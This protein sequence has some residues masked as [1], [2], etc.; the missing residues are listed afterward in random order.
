MFLS[1]RIQNKG[2]EKIA[3]RER[4]MKTFKNILRV[5]VIIVDVLL[6]PAAILCRWLSEQMLE[7][8]SSCLLLQ[9]NGK[10]LSCGGTHFVRDLLS[11]RIFDAFLDNHFFFYVTL[12]LFVTLI[13]ANLYLLFN[14]KFSLKV[15]KCMY[16]IP[17]LLV[18]IFLML[19]FLFA[20]NIPMIIYFVQ[21]A[22]E[23]GTEM[24][25]CIVKNDWEGAIKN[26][27][28]WDTLMR[29]FPFFN[30]EKLNQ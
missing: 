16:N 26:P 29:L 18:T 10:C 22:F 20:R 5:F 27:T 12:Y 15:L 4:K 11:G 3:L 14:L 1:F 6:V 30:F 28:F 9:F 23:I 2:K 21:L 24:G 7:T 17:A 8:D 13:L 25:E 19:L